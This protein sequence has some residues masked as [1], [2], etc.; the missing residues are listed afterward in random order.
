MSHSY[1][2]T[3]HDPTHGP[4]PDFP[5]SPPRRTADGLE[6]ASVLGHH[7]S[8]RCSTSA[9]RD[10]RGTSLAAPNDQSLSMAARSQGP[11]LN[12]RAPS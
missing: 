12:S 1:E 3:A 8:A 9:A 11:S 7:P 6:L 5:P 4:K 10:G 2:S